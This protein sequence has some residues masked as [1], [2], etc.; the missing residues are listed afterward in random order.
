MGFFI[1][2]GTPQPDISA[3]AR[4]VKHLRN[5]HRFMPQ[6]TSSA[7]WNNPPPGKLITLLHAT[8]KA[9]KIGPHTREKMVKV[10]QVGGCLSGDQLPVICWCFRAARK[11]EARCKV[12]RRVSSFSMQICRA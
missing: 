4:Q 11:R 9:S 2:V 1:S 6:I 10:F 12:A 5:D 8:N 7:V 3:F